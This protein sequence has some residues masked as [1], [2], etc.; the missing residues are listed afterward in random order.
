MDY[1]LT[2]YIPLNK[3]F[4]IKKSKKYKNNFMTSANYWKRKFFL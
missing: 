2:T 1:E 3:I 4:K